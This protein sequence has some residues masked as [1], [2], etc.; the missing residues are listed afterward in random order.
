MFPSYSCII[1]IIIILLRFHLFHHLFLCFH[2]C[3][4]SLIFVP[5]SPLVYC[6]IIICNPPGFQYATNV[7]DVETQIIWDSECCWFVFITVE[8]QPS[9]HGNLSGKAGGLDH[10]PSFF[11]FSY[12]CFG[13]LRR[14]PRRKFFSP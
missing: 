4:I 1:I 3:L 2:I 10:S 5:N 6:H 9:T 8:D 7:P 13:H 12:F 14:T 11:V